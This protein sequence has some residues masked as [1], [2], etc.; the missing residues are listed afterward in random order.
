LPLTEGYGHLSIRI[1][2]RFN[3]HIQNI[4]PGERREK[5][6]ADGTREKQRIDQKRVGVVLCKTHQRFPIIIH[7]EGDSQLFAHPP[8]ADNNLAIITIS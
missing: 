7:C 2:E 5:R 1:T 3:S 8:I 6:E 4:S